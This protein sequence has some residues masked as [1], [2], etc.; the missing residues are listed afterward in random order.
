[1]TPW[2]DLTP[3]SRFENKG[4]LNQLPCVMT[5]DAPSTIHFAIPFNPNTLSAEISDLFQF[6]GV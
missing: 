3:T 6:L 2:A 4:L 5:S 1:M